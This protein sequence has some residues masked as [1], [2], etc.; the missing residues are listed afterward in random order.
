MSTSRPVVV[1]IAGFDPSGGAGVLADIKTFE[2]H[3]VLGLGVTTGITYQTENQFYGIEWLDTAK[4]INQ[5]R[6]L[7]DTYD[8]KAVKIGLIQLEQLRA[9]VEVIPE[10]IPLVWDPILSAS[11]GFDFKNGFDI[12]S[13]PGLLPKVDLVTPNLEEFNN[14]ELEGKNIT[15]VLLKGGHHEDHKND[16]LISIDGASVFIEGE[17]FEKSYEKH[18]TGCVLS[19]SITSRIA[20]GDS[21][22]ESCRSGK[23]YVERLLKSNDGLLGYHND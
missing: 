19:A 11:S 23:K 4:V 8:V 7:L 21:L 3:N 22:E 10:I 5:L 13:V 17:S 6:P 18:G 2:Q 15:T 14:L 16:E 1:S 9:V 20:L 12:D